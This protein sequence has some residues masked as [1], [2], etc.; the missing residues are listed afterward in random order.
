MTASGWVRNTVCT[1]STPSSACTVRMP[2]RSSTVPTILRSV[3]LSSA[4][5]TVSC[6]ALSLSTGSAWPSVGVRSASDQTPDRIYEV[7]LIELA[8]EQV[9][10]GA[11]IQAG[12]LVRVVHYQHPWPGPLRLRSG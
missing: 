3:G 4:I 12:P 11:S 2:S 10:A 6:G 5:T 7:G 8:L 9:S 1:A